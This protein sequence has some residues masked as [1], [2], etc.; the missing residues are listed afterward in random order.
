MT[1]HVHLLVTPHHPD[2]LAKTLQSIG[3][4]YVQYFNSTYQRTGT[5]WEGRYRAT[6]ID[7]EHYL[8]RCYRYIEWN[9]VRARIVT[10]PRAYPWSSYWYH[11]EGK[12]DRLITDH[13]L[14]LALGKTGAERQ[15]GYR[16]LSKVEVEEESVAAIREGTNKAWVLGS[17]GF[18]DKMA[19][20]LQRRVQ[21]LARG[22]PRKQVD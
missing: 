1:N 2:T 7:T 10:H 22:R 5:L 13:V 6:L 9:P 12:A 20:V 14:Y 17:E 19:A 8:L 3:R 11:A 21:P 16:E 18:K 4:R 15:R